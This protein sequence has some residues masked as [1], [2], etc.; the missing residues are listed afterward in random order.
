VR[1]SSG[2]NGLAFALG[3]QN[4]LEIILFGNAD[5]TLHSKQDNV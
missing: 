4:S 3:F 2:D 5:G 1:E